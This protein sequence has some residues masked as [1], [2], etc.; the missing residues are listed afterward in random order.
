MSMLGENLRPRT[1]LRKLSNVGR[2]S[3]SRASAVDE[4]QPFRLLDLPPEVVE[5]ILSLSRPMAVL[6]LRKTCTALN[7]ASRDRQTWLVIAQRT[8]FEHNMP[9]GPKKRAAMSFSDLE[10]FATA[11]AR[12]LRALSAASGRYYLGADAK[13]IPKIRARRETIHKGICSEHSSYDEIYILPGGQYMINVDEEADMTLWRLDS[14][15]PITLGKIPF[16]PRAESEPSRINRFHKVCAHELICDGTE[17]RFVTCMGNLRETELV[18]ISVYDICLEGVESSLRLVASTRVPLRSG[19]LFSNVI[20]LFGTRIAVVDKDDI[21][22]WDFAHDQQTSWP[23]LFGHIH[24]WRVLAYD[25]RVIVVGCPADPEEIFKRERGQEVEKYNVRAKISVFE[26]PI[27]AVGPIQLLP[28]LSLCLGHN[29]FLHFPC[30]A[31][32]GAPFSFQVR[33]CQSESNDLLH[34]YA[35]RQDLGSTRRSSEYLSVAL[36]PSADECLARTSVTMKVSCDA[37]HALVQT[38]YSFESDSRYKKIHLAWPEQ[39]NGRRLLR[40][41]VMLAYGGKSRM[42]AQ[43]FDPVSGRLCALR[44]DGGLLVADYI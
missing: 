23:H 29:Q 18:Q 6:A 35:L 34:T 5:V 32:P 30:R 28:G 42:R 24:D 15:T 1:L 10:R 14:A 37:G 7:I 43:A 44:S 3:R 25:N 20:S 33:T 16:Q 11:P 38:G 17:L 40:G 31:V 26:I 4:V 8:A 22:V 39:I 36:E 21:V 2:R 27:D 41:S 9:L 19:S 13:Q 12:S